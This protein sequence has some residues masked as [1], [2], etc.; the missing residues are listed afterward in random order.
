MKQLAT[1][2]FRNGLMFAV[3]FS[4]IRIKQANWPRLAL[5]LWGSQSS[6]ADNGKLCLWVGETKFALDGRATPTISVCKIY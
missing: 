4:C 2:H 3:I 5:E 6:S 1:M